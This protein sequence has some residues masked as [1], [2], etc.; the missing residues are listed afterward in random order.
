MRHRYYAFAGVGVFVL[1]LLYLSIRSTP[2]PLDQ[3]PDDRE[4]AQRAC[5]TSVLEEVPDG[6]F[7]FDAN[8]EDQGEGRLR[9]SGSIDFGSGAQASRQNYECFLQ[10]GP[11]GAYTAD[12]VTVWRSH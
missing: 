4:A 10:R 8:I 6:R 5:Q 12:S 2:T 3:S 7:P 11:S 9:L 1:L